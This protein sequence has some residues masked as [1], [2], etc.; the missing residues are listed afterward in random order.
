MKQSKETQLKITELVITDALESS[1]FSSSK[2]TSCNFDDADLRNTTFN[3]SEMTASVFIGAKING[4]F[5]KD[6]DFRG[7]HFHGA[8]FTYSD[9]EGAKLPDGYGKLPNTLEEFKWQLECRLGRGEAVFNPELSTET[10][11]KDT[12]TLIAY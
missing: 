12:K 6:A 5:F 4:G 1:N 11:I 8:D 10:E 9:F 7:G 2:M 3:N